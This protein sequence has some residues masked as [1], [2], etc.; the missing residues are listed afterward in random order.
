M[1]PQDREKI[2]A[3][4][5]EEHDR[6]LGY[7]RQRV[8]KS[9]EAEDILQDV[10]YQLTTGFNEAKKIENIAGWIYRVTNNRIIDRYRKKNID[11]VDLNLKESSDEGDLISLEEILP[12]LGN[13]PED[14]E[15]KE[16]MWEIIEETLEELPPEQSEIFVLHEFE[17]LSFKSISEMKQIPVNSLISRKRYAVL[18]LRKRLQAI[19]I[20]LREK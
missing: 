1:S 20:M 12:D 19:Y 4:Y 6:L 11:T 15:L 14:E 7:I 17:D 10:F 3:T 13:S 2:E 16:I 8:P 9:Y 5:R 18:E